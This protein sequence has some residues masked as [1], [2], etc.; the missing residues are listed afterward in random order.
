MTSRYASLSRAEL[1]ALVPELLLIGQLIDR[2]GMAWCIVEFGREEMLQ[3]A[4]E[5][6]A[7]SSPLYTKRMQKTLKYEGVDIAFVSAFF[8]PPGETLC[9]D[10]ESGL[11]EPRVP[12][13]SETGLLDV[14]VSA[15]P[16]DA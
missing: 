12:V 14:D 11:P 7:G 10:S 4:I 2:A 15:G 8:V 13:V 6:W 16:R 5:E 9:A 1:A 3:V